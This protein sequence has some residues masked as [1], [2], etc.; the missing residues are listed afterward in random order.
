VTDVTTLKTQ[1]DDVLE[2][3]VEPTPGVWVV[4]NHDWHRLLRAVFDDE[5]LAR[6]WANEHHYYVEFLPFGQEWT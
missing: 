2:R 4:Y 5:L 3:P 6:R 1:N